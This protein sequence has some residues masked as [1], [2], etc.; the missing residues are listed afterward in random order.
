[1]NTT[2]EL[3]PLTQDEIDG[4]K[5]VGV[6]AENWYAISYDKNTKPYALFQNED[7]AMAYRDQF[8]I[9][10]IVEPWPMIVKD[11]RKGS[12]L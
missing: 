7:H 5:T 1:M 2:T 10:S 6:I 4:L 3:K 12:K 9:T 8:S 11:Y